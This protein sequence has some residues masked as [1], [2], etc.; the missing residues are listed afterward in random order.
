MHLTKLLLT[1][2]ILLPSSIYAREI[3][4]SP[5]APGREIEEIIAK[6]TLSP[7]ENIRS[8]L[9]HRTETVSIHIVQIRFK[10]KPHI[11]KDHDLFVTLKKG[12]G[13]LH[14]GD[15]IIKMSVN[16]SAFISKGEPHWFENTSEG[17]SA[18]LVV[19]APAYDGKDNIPVNEAK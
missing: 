10:E 8:T 19:F 13:V 14:A 7:G 1:T 9:M 3:F 2:L 16:D 4:Y 15:K 18:G 5:S 11:H 6:E 12:G 17:I